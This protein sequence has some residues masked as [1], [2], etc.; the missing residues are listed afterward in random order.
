MSS[1]VSTLGLFTII[2]L[3]SADCDISGKDTD[4][5]GVSDDC[6]NCPTIKNP[7]QTDS[8]E[9]GFGDACDNT[10]PTGK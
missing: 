10:Y 1:R 2:I 4:E 6:D 9:D 3:F 8:N 7:E 5:D